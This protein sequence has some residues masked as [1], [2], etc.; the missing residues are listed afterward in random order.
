MVKY[1]Y[2]D[3]ASVDRLRGRKYVVVSIPRQMLVFTS[4]SKE[5]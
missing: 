1:S 5:Q 3:D 2:F 4:L